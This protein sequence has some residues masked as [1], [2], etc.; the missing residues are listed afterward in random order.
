MRFHFHPLHFA[1]ALDVLH[2]E[3]SE[4][5]KGKDAELTL[6]LLRLEIAF[7]VDQA[8]TWAAKH[9]VPFD[10]PRPDSGCTARKCIFVLRRL[11]VALRDLASRAASLPMND[12]AAADGDHD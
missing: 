9:N 10:F 12:N 1:D 3:L 6:S 11:S 2:H 5:L 8:G 7:A 4:D